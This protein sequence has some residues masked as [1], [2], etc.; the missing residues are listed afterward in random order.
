MINPYPVQTCNTC[1]DYEIVKPDGRGFPPDIA[2]NRLRKRCEAKGCEHNIS[3][4]A[5]FQ[6]RVDKSGF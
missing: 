1:Q 6:V 5:G 2:K 4:R 3:Y